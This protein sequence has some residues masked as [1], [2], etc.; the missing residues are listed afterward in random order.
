MT[1]VRGISLES[2]L[3]LRKTKSDALRFPDFRR[4][5]PVSN[6]L[7]SVGE[8]FRRSHASGFRFRYPIGTLGCQES[9]LQARERLN[10][11]SEKSVPIP[12]LLEQEQESMYPNSILNSSVELFDI[13]NDEWVTLPSMNY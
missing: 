6:P 13:S 11:P 1:L 12:R 5:N 9:D 7:V 8:V 2:R 3:Q 4:K 10:Q